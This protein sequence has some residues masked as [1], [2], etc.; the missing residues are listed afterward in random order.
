MNDNFFSK[1]ANFEDAF[2]SDESN[3]V[4]RVDLPQE[5]AQRIKQM[6]VSK[7]LNPGDLL[8]SEPKLCK[9]FG[10]GRSTVREAVK[11]LK[12]ENIIEIKKGIGTFV[13]EMP[14]VSKDPLGITLMDQKRALK[15]LMETRLMIEPNISF[16][17]AQRATADNIVKIEKIIIETD[18]V[19]ELNQNHMEVDMAFHNA[20]AEATQND[21]LF[22]I[23]PTINDSIQAGYH[24][25]YN[26]I[27]SFQKATMFHREVFEAIKKRHAQEALEAMKCHIMQS[28]DDILV[29]LEEENDS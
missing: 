15:N 23:I 24:E 1:T 17:A 11:I 9:I 22:R 7:Y 10:I 6:I 20:I 4:S 29:K 12:A 2:N 5:I 18:R 21:V 27:G 25:T 28:M 14:G 3:A 13:V 8:P 16:L 26:L 19:L